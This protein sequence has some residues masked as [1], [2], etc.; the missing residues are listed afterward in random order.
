MTVLLADGAQG[1]QALAGRDLGPSRWIVLDQRRINTFADSIDDDEWIHVDTAKARQGPFGTTIAH[2]FHSVALVPPAVRTL[3]EV[4]GF[5][6]TL[7]YGL[8]KLRFPSPI[9]EGSRVRVRGTVAS[10]TAARRGYEMALDFTVE[11]EGSDRPAAA[12]QLIYLY[13][14]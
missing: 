13:L 8:N 11:M 3:L 6:S 9:P 4:R 14:T 2:G 7:I 5:R 12:G 1:L 10:V